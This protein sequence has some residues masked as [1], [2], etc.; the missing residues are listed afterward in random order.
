MT[1]ILELSTVTKRS[2]LEKN[3][4]ML[5]KLPRNANVRGITEKPAVPTTAPG[6]TGP[7]GAPF[8]SA[9]EPAADGHRPEVDAAA[10]GRGVQLDEQRA[11]V[12]L[13]RDGLAEADHRRVVAGVAVARLAVRL[14]RHL[15]GVQLR[16]L[17]R[18]V[19][20]ELGDLLALGAEDHEPVGR[21]EA[22]HG[23]HDDDESAV[24]GHLAL[25]LSAGRG[26]GRA[27][28]APSGLAAPGVAACRAQAW[29]R[30]WRASPVPAGS[31]D[32][33]ASFSK[34]MIRSKLG[35]LVPR[36]QALTSPRSFPAD[37]AWVIERVRR[38]LL[39]G[40]GEADARHAVDVAQA[41]HQLGDVGLAG[42]AA[43]QLDGRA[44]RSRRASARRR[45]RCPSA[46]RRCR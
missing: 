43:L 22:D 25:P 12:V 10:L 36:P 9:A 13:R 1:L 24:A 6:T 4:D 40:L 46:R 21:G 19:R 41:R 31:T 3:C 45:R 18:D 5:E 34:N 38:G 30:P 26:R 27:A 28:A 33:S 7:A 23:R 29:R 15:G 16:L 11:R 39:V 14:E 44:R 8:E 35:L 42:G 2:R 17:G 32:A 37:C 20:V